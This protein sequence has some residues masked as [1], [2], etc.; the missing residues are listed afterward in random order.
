MKLPLEG[1]LADDDAISVKRP[2][3]LVV[4]EWWDLNDYVRSRV[5]K[6]ARLGYV[7]FALD[8]NGKAVFRGNFLKCVS[9]LTAPALSDMQ[10]YH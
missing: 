2:G 1:Y 3:V 4:H 9:M 5:D 6:L 8:M 10:E 7:A